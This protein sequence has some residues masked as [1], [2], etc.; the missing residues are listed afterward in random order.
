MIGSIL[1]GGF[2]AHPFIKAATI[3]LTNNYLESPFGQPLPLLLGTIISSVIGTGLTK[4]FMLSHVGQD[5][6]WIC[7]IVATALS[8]IAMSLT[9]TLHPAAASSA[10]LCAMNKQVRENLGW[11]YLVDQ[12]VLFLITIGFACLFGNM[13]TKYPLYWLLPPRL[14]TTKSNTPFPPWLKI[15]FDH[16]HHQEKNHVTGL[17]KSSQVADIPT[18][19]YPNS[20]S[21]DLGEYNQN[22][23][24]TRDYGDYG[25]YTDTDMYSEEEYHTHQTKTR[26][27]REGFS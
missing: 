13:Y 25:D 15:I 1:T 26:D 10:F 18:E 24:P 2:H 12:I 23:S 6:L 11:F 22:E 3:I 8:S 4:I 19:D 9:G 17:S 27:G 5:H 20:C 14:E 7:G 16:L 21:G